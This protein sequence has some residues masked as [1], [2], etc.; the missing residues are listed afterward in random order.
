MMKFILKM[1]V[2]LRIRIA[3]LVFVFIFITIALALLFHNYLGSMLA[4]GVKTSY[5]SGPCGW[6]LL[7]LPVSFV[8]KGYLRVEDDI[9][10][11]LK[12]RDDKDRI[13]PYLKDVIEKRKPSM[14]DAIAYLG[15]FKAKDNSVG[16]IIE[17]AYVNLP[18]S[19]ERTLSLYSLQVYKPA[20]ADRL[21]FRALESSD[22]NERLYAIG[23]ACGYLGRTNPRLAEVLKKG[24]A[25]R[26]LLNR[27]RTVYMISLWNNRD[28]IDLLKDA[29]E[30]EHDTSLRDFIQEAIDRF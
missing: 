24:L 26:V 14:F 4:M 5:I 9:R 18:V 17:A 10:E 3:V 21:F 23:I 8:A 7:N 30:T 16:D 19:L 2:K 13:V 27:R 15:S 20:A 12:A 22:P 1:K 25:D 29:L 28:H 11:W 6:L